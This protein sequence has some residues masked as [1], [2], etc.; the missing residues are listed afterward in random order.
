MEK[1]HVITPKQLEQLK[2]LAAAPAIAKLIAEIKA[3]GTFAG[4]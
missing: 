4:R 3:N 2:S 1:L